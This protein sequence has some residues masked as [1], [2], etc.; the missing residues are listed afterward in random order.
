MAGL[1]VLQNLVNHTFIHQVQAGGP[2]GPELGTTDPNTVCVV[3]PENI[4]L[5]CKGRLKQH[6]RTI[7]FY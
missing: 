7:I 2:G 6:K 4:I 5:V 1:H 3:D